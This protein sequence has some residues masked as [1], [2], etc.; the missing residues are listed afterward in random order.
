M[1][2][3]NGRK[4]RVDMSTA[5]Y[6]AYAVYFTDGLKECKFIRKEMV[7]LLYYT[8]NGVQS[9]IPE[10]HVRMKDDSVWHVESLEKNGVFLNIFTD[11]KDFNF[12]A[13]NF[14]PCMV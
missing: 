4:C 12:K 10:M 7:N 1:R 9:V 2:M 6:P 8:N 11:G 13:E 3:A 5:D 14:T